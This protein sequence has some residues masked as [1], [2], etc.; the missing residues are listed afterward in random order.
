[1]ASPQYE[2]LA[3]IND[4]VAP[5]VKFKSHDGEDDLLREF[6]ERVLLPNGLMFSETG[7]IIAETQTGCALAHV[8]ISERGV[9]LIDAIRILRREG[10]AIPSELYRHLMNSDGTY[11]ADVARD[12]AGMPVVING[13]TL[14]AHLPFSGNPNAN[15]LFVS[16]R[17]IPPNAIAIAFVHK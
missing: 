11:V 5:W 9:A 2:I 13:N 7:D 8:K 16:K 6:E 15:G 3:W 17:D 12:S 14:V 4:V 1:M 10:V